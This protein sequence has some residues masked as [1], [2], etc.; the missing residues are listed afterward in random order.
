MQVANKKRMLAAFKSIK[1][2]RFHTLQKVTFVTTAESVGSALFGKQ[3]G[4]GVPLCPKSKRPLKGPI[5]PRK[6][7]VDRSALD[8]D[9]RAEEGSSVGIAREQRR[10]NRRSDKDES[11]P[12]DLFAPRNRNFS[13]KP[14]CAPVR[15]RYRDDAAEIANVNFTRPVIRDVGNLRMSGRTR[16]ASTFVLRSCICSP[17]CGL[18]P[19]IDRPLHRNSKMIDYQCLLPREIV[20]VEKRSARLPQNNRAA[21]NQFSH[22][23]ECFG[24]HRACRW[25]YDNRASAFQCN[26]GEAT[27]RCAQCRSHSGERLRQ[28]AVRL[29]IQQRATGNASP[30]GI[31]R[32][33]FERG[34]RAQTRSSS[35][36]TRCAHEFSARYLHS[37]PAIRRSMSAAVS[38]NCWS[39]AYL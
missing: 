4:V 7:R 25:N 36:A 9:Q 30:G 5:K 32:S 28:C 39:C 2:S 37:V 31:A 12:A 14:D 13:P 16:A 15:S 6:E 3:P 29:K 24:S 10:S 27:M 33:E 38:G 11:S 18:R 20:G 22:N 34:N 17:Q 21:F 19:H 23:A 35:G 26:L 8:A 1:F